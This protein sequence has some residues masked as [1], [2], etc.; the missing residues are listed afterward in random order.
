MAAGAEVVAG[1]AFDVGAGAS[2]DVLEVAAASARASAGGGGSSAAVVF[3]VNLDVAAI[4]GRLVEQ[5]LLRVNDGGGGAAARHRWVHGPRG[6]AAAV[7]ADAWVARGNYLVVDLSAA[8]AVLSSAVVGEGA[9][10]PGML[11]RVPPG[12]NDGTRGAGT[13][14]ARIAALVMSGVEHALAPDVAGRAAF[15]VPAA[16]A[17]QRGATTVE[18]LTV[19][20]GGADA[21][22]A[23]EAWATLEAGLR[24]CEP[25]GAQHPI[26]FR[27]AAVRLR[28]YPELSVALAA[29]CACSRA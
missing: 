20:A 4:R 18:L 8:D 24:Q 21:G 29:V 7:A 17:A 10:T 19:T 12:A 22:T 1:G 15:S 13:L 11:P 2:E 25:Q 23:D 27:R 6:T 9:V 5:G 16:A 14:A 28:D 26:V 3:I